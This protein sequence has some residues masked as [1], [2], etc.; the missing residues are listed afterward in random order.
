VVSR[1]NYPIRV[2]I[3]ISKPKSIKIID[4]CLKMPIEIIREV[5]PPPTPKTFHLIEHKE[6]DQKTRKKGSKC[7]LETWD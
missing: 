1:K 4:V 3:S 5:L 6:I 7:L 2:H